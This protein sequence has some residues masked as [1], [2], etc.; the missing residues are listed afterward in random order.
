MKILSMDK[1]TGK[2]TE[3]LNHLK[4]DD[5]TVYISPT[6]QWASQLRGVV[7]NRF[8]WSDAQASERILSASTAAEKLRQSPREYALLVDELDS[9][10]SVLLGNRAVKIGTITER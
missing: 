4:Y 9:V 5:R 1:F 7:K 2:T 6:E 10:L 8:G 3:L